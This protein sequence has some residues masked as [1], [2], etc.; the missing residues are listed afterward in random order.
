[1]KY[2]TGFALSQGKQKTPQALIAA[3]FKKQDFTSRACQ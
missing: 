1:M 2:K 3:F